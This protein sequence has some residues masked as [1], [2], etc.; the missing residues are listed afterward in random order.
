MPQL[1]KDPIT[2]RW[3][4]ISTDRAKR[5]SDFFR[6]RVE[7]KGIGLCPFCSG[8]ESKTPPEV[9]A[10]GRNGTGPNSPGWTVR[11]VPNKF[12]ALGIE[13]ALDRQGIG[14]F[15][16][17]N[18]VGAHEVIIETPDHQ[19]TLA[20]LGEGEVEQVLCA[21]RDR[22]SDL[23]NDRRFRYMLVFKNHGEAAGASLE[24]THSQLIALP[25]VPKQVNEEVENAQRYFEEK[26]RCIF[27]DIIR[28]EAEDGERVI[29]ENEHCVA[30][31]PYA[32]R[33]PFETWIL[34]KKHSSA[35][36]F[37][38][39]GVFSSLASLLRNMLRRIDQVLDHPPYNY[40]VHT[41]PV[42]E[43]H[44]EHYHW[45]I[46]MMPTLTKVAGF[47]W[48]AGFYINPTPP[49]ESAKFLREAEG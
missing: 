43:E 12:P 22:M 2:H 39:P 6:S 17:M 32:P 46:E 36:E 3:V 23:K 26:E 38:P 37:E 1:R 8:N 48:G 31:A 25:I 18:G 34:P 19:S 9:L 7:I 45:H 27:C 29:A 33:F 41:S 28:Q 35:F 40:V 15:D 4:I 20:T 5:P 13:G 30:L 21:Y 16:M 49:E 47:E 24:H 11:V 14:L 44:N 10:Y 42:G